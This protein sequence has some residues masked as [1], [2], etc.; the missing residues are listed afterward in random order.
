MNLLVID[1][2]ASRV[3]IGL[4]EAGE[5]LKALVTGHFD[6]VT[7]EDI[8]LRDCNGRIVASNMV[9]LGAGDPPHLGWIAQWLSVR[10]YRVDAICHRLGDGGGGNGEA[11]NYMLSAYQNIPQLVCPAPG[12]LVDVAHAA[13]AALALP[14]PHSTIASPQ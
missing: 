10:N 3:C 6:A 5:S 14:L 8:E 11:L 2:V 12:T 9:A 7:G 13:M 4:F 1:A